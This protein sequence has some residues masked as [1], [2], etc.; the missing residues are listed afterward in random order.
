MNNGYQVSQKNVLVG[1]WCE[2]KELSGKTIFLT[3]KGGTTARG[4]LLFLWLYFLATYIH[5]FP[6]SP[7]CHL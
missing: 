3:S 6:S 4:Q 7:F 5:H 2:A 1:H